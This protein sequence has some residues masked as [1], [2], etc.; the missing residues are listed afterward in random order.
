MFSRVV[1]KSFV[2]ACALRALNAS[3]AA[4]DGTCA[5]ASIVTR[6]DGTNQCNVYKTTV[7]IFFNSI[8]INGNVRQDVV[9]E[10][11]CSPAGQDGGYAS[12]GGAF[13]CEDTL[14]SVQLPMLMLACN[15]GKYPSGTKSALTCVDCAAGTYSAASKLTCT[16]CAANTYSASAATSC[17]PCAS[18]SGSAAGATA[19]T[20][21]SAGRYGNSYGC[22]ACSLPLGFGPRPLPLLLSCVPCPFCP[23]K[24]TEL[25]VK[26]ASL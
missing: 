20:T 3:T 26:V 24:V 10:C 7:E 15:A 4:T 16:T 18:G 1:M 2:L 8:T 9:D 21:C 11:K 23:L 13:H 5:S 12:L 22:Q 19:C 25:F 17:T 14:T 6:D